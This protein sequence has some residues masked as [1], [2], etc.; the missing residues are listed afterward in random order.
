MQLEK[1]AETYRIEKEN[2]DCDMAECLH[3]YSI[4][5]TS[6][7]IF[8]LFYMGSLENLNVA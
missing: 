4:M 1:Q 3:S 2:V 6:P 5:P 8:S 7:F